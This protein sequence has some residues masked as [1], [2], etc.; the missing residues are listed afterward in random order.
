LSHHDFLKSLKDAWGVEADRNPKTVRGLLELGESAKTKPELMDDLVAAADKL[1]EPLAEVLDGCIHDVETTEGIDPGLLPH[2]EGSITAY[3]LILEGTEMIADQPEHFAEALVLIDE[4][5]KM[6]QQHQ[7][8]IEL[9]QN[10]PA[11]PL[12]GTRSKE[13][14][15]CVSCG[16]HL[17]IPDRNPPD[18]PAVVL[19]SNYVELRKVAGLVAT[20]KTPVA[21]LGQAVEGL[22][23]ELFKLSRL[24]RQVTDKAF[25]IQPFLAVLE[26]AFGGLERMQ[27]FETTC[28]IADLNQGWLAV[29]EAGLELQKMAESIP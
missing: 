13:A 16:V 17:V 12:C 20:G 5:V 6:Q 14:R 7:D 10:Q 19:G 15:T 24:L 8:G 9:W 18:I 26:R 28:A 21:A 1:C 11:C 2:L 25:D 27:S 29:A 3:Q 4:G 22:A 23:S